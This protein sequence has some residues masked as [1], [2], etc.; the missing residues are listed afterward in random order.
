MKKLLLS[1]FAP[2]FLIA[3]SEPVSESVEVVE[4]AGEPVALVYPVTDKVDHVDNYHGTDVADSFRWLEDDVRESE[5]VASW[6]EDEN[7]VTFAYLD[8][9]EERAAIYSRMKELWDYERFSLPVKEGGRYF[10]SYNNGLQNQNVIYTLIDL[11][12]EPDLLIDPNTWSDDGTVAL[13]S[14]F[15]SPDGKHVAYLVQDG[16]SDWRVGKVMNVETGEVL[17]DKLDWLKFTTLS[18][19]G[20]SSGFYY[21]RFP[22]TKDEEKFQSLNKDMTVY[23]H[24]LGTLQEQDRVAYARPDQPDWL[25]GATVTDDGE[26][27][28]VSIV[29]GTDERHSIVHQDLTDPKAEPVMIIEGFDY[30]Y[31]LVG[32]IGN[33][34]Y[35]RTNDVAPRNRLIAI[36]AEQPGPEHWREVIAQTDDV[37]DGVSLVGGKVIATYMQDAKTVVKVMDLEGNETG[38][39]DLPGIGTA[40]GSNA[41][42]CLPQS[43]MRSW[44]CAA[45]RRPCSSIPITRRSSPSGWPPTSSAKQSWA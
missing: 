15:P 24:E 43:T 39:V 4:V 36:N 38:T 1:L 29:V 42:R 30:D 28:V 19:A 40:S 13:A 16:G 44:P 7:K 26:H 14:Y 33:E 21:S 41:S 34:L 25:M 11:D 23:F 37:L 10:Y 20:D 3:C 32:N 8:T 5:A 2:L 6:V 18:W 45:A 9:I 27:L 31:T 35:F 22:A 12:A 17:T